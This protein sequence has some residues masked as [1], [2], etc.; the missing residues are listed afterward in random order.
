MLLVGFLAI[1]NVLTE[2]FQRSFAVGTVRSHGF[3]GFVN[4][5]HSPRSQLLGGR[6]LFTTVGLSKSTVRTN[7]L[8]SFIGGVHSTWNQ[9]LVLGLLTITNLCTKGVEAT[10]TAFAL[11]VFSMFNH[12]V[13]TH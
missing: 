6:F 12:L 10:A 2:G 3:I 5:I 11:V 9:L 13:A 1:A 4:L 7:D 8:S